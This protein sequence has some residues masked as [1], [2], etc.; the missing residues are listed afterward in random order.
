[1]PKPIPGMQKRTR[2]MLA[3]QAAAVIRS[4]FYHEHDGWR[5]QSLFLWVPENGQ[6]KEALYTALRALGDTPTPESVDTLVGTTLLTRL[7]CHLCRRD[8]LEAVEIAM[9]CE[10]CK[11][12]T[13]CHECLMRALRF[14]EM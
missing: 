7:T 2:E 6:T 3:A 8:C 14:F 10:E 13:V 1:M 4:A 11:A 5:E 12:C 9:P